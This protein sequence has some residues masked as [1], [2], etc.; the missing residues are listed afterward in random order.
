MLG[1]MDRSC[2]PG[3]LRDAFVFQVRHELRE[4]GEG[5]GNQQRNRIKRIC[6]AIGANSWQSNDVGYTTSQSSTRR[7]ARARCPACKVLSA[8]ERLVG[9]L[10]RKHGHGSTKSVCQSLQK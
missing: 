6:H 10:R 4:Q 8:H 9:S 3:R 5:R 1:P 2:A 7:Q